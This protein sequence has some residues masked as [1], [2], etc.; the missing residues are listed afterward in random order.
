MAGLEKSFQKVESS[1]NG[2]EEFFLIAK[3]WICWTH[4]CNKKRKRE[5]I[6]YIFV[7]KFWIFVNNFYSKVV[8][9]VVTVFVGNV[10]IGEG[11]EFQWLQEVLD[12]LLWP[13]N[14]ENPIFLPM[15]SK[16]KQQHQKQYLRK[17]ST[18]S[19]KLKIQIRITAFFMDHFPQHKP[20]SIQCFCCDFWNF[21]LSVFL[22]TATSKTVPRKKFEIHL[23]TEK[24]N[25]NNSIYHG[26]LAT[27]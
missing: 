16:L 18:F 15:L 12:L 26:P 2:F 21:E 7:H 3:I 13:W 27:T 4:T 5:L 25:T 22:P 11:M 1:T 9:L 14:F 24:S 20:K 6:F 17:N 10:Q 8:L 23:E 19:F